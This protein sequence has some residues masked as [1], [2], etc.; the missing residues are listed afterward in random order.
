MQGAPSLAQSLSGFFDELTRIMRLRQRA[1][2]EGR[3]RDWRVDDGPYSNSL[4][5]DETP[6]S[7]YRVQPP[8]PSQPEVVVRGGY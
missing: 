5:Q 7:W 2:E 6:G 1:V 3:F 4:L 8:D